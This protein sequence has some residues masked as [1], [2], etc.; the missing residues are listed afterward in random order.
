MGWYIGEYPTQ[1]NCNT[2]QPFVAIRDHLSC[3][4]RSSFKSTI[5]YLWSTPGVLWQPSFHELPVP[6]ATSQVSSQL[7]PWPKCLLRP[8]SYWRW[9]RPAP[10]AGAP[11]WLLT[12]PWTMTERVS[13]VG[14]PKGSPLP[15]AR[16][17]AP[18]SPPYSADDRLAPPDTL[19]LALIPGDLPGLN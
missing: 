2:S 12:L 11:S 3:L 4:D 18:P 6:G 9:L 14:K 16:T 17:E 8:G 15:A 19:V 5:S 7:G 10:V 13:Y 1:S